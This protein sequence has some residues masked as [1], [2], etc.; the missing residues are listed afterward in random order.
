[1]SSEFSRF[2]SGFLVVLFFI[3]SI[4]GGVGVALGAVLV[5]LDVAGGGFVDVAF[6]LLA[7]ARVAFGFVD[8]LLFSVIF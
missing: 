2:A 4:G 6:V 3:V 5:V 1:M 8:I 7:V